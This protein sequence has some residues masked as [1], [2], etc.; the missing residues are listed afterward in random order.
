LNALGF[1][2]SV[3]SAVCERVL[4][5][6]STLPVNAG[7]TERFVLAAVLSAY[8]RNRALRCSGCGSAVGRVPCAAVLPHTLSSYDNLFCGCIRKKG[9]TFFHSLLTFIVPGRTY[10]GADAVV[11]YGFIR[12]S[13]KT[14]FAWRAVR[15]TGRTLLRRDAAAR[16]TCPTICGVH[17]WLLPRVR[18]GTKRQ[19]AR[20]RTVKKT[21]RILILYWR[22]VT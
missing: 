2:S 20:R 19:H 9:E 17:A 5:P 10:T 12:R 3:P 11:R 22:R 8:L 6:P 7:W 15:S 14:L 21:L 1:F 4:L 18:T 13:F 16:A